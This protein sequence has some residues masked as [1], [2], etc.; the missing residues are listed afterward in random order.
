M[1]FKVNDLML[2]VVPQQAPGFHPA[3]LADPFDPLAKQ[4]ANNTCGPC[5][6]CASCSICSCT[7]TSVCSQACSGGCSGCSL[8][9]N[10]T[11]T[12]TLLTADQAALGGAE[13]DGIVR[14]AVLLLSGKGLEALQQQMNLEL[15][16]VSNPRRP[17]AFAN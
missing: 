8:C 1:S 3:L 6:N 17:L 2:K 9:T 15:M 13:S 12:C 4:F 5:T 7:C 14:G 16:R 10:C 11:C